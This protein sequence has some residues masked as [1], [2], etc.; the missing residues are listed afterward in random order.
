MVK[1]QTT[2][3]RVDT[4]LRRADKEMSKVEMRRM[5]EDAA[6]NTAALPVEGEERGGCDG[7]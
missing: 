2:H 6:R 5:L 4:T 7:V 1:S 3:H